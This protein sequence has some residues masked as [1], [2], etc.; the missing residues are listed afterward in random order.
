MPDFYIEPMKSIVVEIKA[1]N[2]HYGKNRYSCGFNGLKSY[3]LRIAWLNEIRDDKTPEQA[4]SAKDVE[5][6]YKA[7]EGLI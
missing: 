6:L 7:Q 4:S 2:I 3:S 5:Y 1:M